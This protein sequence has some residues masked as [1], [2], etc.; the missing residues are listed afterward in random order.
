MGT[1]RQHNVVATRRCIGSDCSKV[2]SKFTLKFERSVMI[3][4]VPIHCLTALLKRLRLFLARHLKPLQLF[5][6][7]ICG[8]P[9]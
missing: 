5:S 3:A 8:S 6:K 9:G 4:L 1:E 2:N 7:V